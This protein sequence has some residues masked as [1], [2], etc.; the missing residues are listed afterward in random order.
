MKQHQQQSSQDVMTSNRITVKFKYHDEF[1]IPM[2]YLF[3]FVSIVKLNISN[4]QQESRDK[5]RERKKKKRMK[6]ARDSVTNEKHLC[7]SQRPRQTDRR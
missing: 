5:D 4:L 6:I 1:S 3:I 7:I 2:V